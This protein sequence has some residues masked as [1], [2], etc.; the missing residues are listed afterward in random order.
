MKRYRSTYWQRL[1]DDDGTLAPDFARHLRDCA[2]P[3]QIAFQR[4]MAMT[5]GNPIGVECKSEA[6]DSWAFVLPDVAGE[7][8]WRVQNF[9]ADS[10]FGHQCHDSLQQAVEAMLGDGYRILDPGALDRCSS[11][12]RWATGVKRSGIRLLFNL[13]QI[14]WPEMLLRM[15]LVTTSRQACAMSAGHS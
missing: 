1:R 12:E 13:G 11:T 10:F 7:S 15:Q 9:D 4:L 5:S 3:T 2:R 6:R 14:D 8:P